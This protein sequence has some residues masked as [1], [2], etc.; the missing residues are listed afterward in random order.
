MAQGGL[1]V[2]GDAAVLPSLQIR[3]SPGCHPAAPRCPPAGSAAASLKVGEGFQG[4]QRW[5][6]PQLHARPHIL[7]SSTVLALHVASDLMIAA[8]RS[9]VWAWERGQ[10][11][12]SEL[13]LHNC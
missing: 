5:G 7:G 3:M 10:E 4:A 6:S 11:N 2:G 8:L 12:G 9:Q 1:Q 13:L